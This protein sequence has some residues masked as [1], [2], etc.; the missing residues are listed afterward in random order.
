MQLEQ[1]AHLA[2]GLNADAPSAGRRVLLHACGDVHGRAHGGVV[3]FHTRAQRHV[4]AVHAH[5]HGEVG[6]GM[7]PCS[8]CRLLAPGCQDGQPRAHGAFGIVLA[9]LVHAEGG[10]HAVAGETQHAALVG[11]DE[12]GHAP[13]RRTQQAQRVLG[14]HAV[15]HCRGAHHVGKQHRHQAV[16]QAGGAQ[17]GGQAGAQRGGGQLKHRVAQRGALGFQR[18]DGGFELLLFSRHELDV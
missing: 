7:K 14:C 8:G 15:G 12:D 2:P 13:R 9:R 18:G 4:T 17:Q 1:P 16:L 11:F 3:V 6:D 5:A 10:L